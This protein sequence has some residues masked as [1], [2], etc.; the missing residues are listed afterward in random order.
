MGEINNVLVMAISRGNGALLLNVLTSSSAAFLSPG[1]EEKD[2]EE[3]VCW[4]P[5]ELFNRS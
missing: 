1:Q 3:G 2:E 4:W 5:R